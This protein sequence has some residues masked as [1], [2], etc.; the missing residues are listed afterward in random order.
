MRIKGL[1]INL[2]PGVRISAKN[3]CLQIFRFSYQEDVR[4][5]RGGSCRK[6]EEEGG[7]S[8]GGVGGGGKKERTRGKKTIKQTERKENNKRKKE[9]GTGWGRSRRDRHI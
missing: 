5:G 8:G 1:L 4:G 2:R 7:G 6:E 3:R 9:R